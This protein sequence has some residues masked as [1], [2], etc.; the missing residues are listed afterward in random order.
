MRSLDDLAVSADVG[1]RANLP[2]LFAGR[3]H[4]RPFEVRT[5]FVEAEKEVEA[6][7][8]DLARLYTLLALA[9]EAM[10]KPDRT[11]EPFQPLMTFENGTRTPVPADFGEAHLALLS[12][13]SLSG[14]PA[15]FSARIADILWTRRYRAGGGPPAHAMVAINAY[16]EDGRHQQSGPNWVYAAKSLERAV[17]L[18][19]LI[20]KRGTGVWT[21][22]EAAV[23]EFADAFEA[24]GQWRGLLDA[25]AL[26]YE[27]GIGE[28][29]EK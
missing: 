28:A 22:A 5:I 21:K 27:F 2:Q 16:L 18:A 8:P 1:A 12:A 23:A 24:A 9:F 10:L 7:D 6:S 17:R 4:L 19:F 26:M 20:D 11:N 15:V 29:D 14:L 3:R 25:F 13:I